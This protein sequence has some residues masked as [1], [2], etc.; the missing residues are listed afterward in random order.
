MKN[1]ANEIQQQLGRQN[2]CAFCWIIG[3]CNLNQVNTHNL[4]AL[5]KALQQLQNFII[6]K[7]AMAGGA[8]S[9]VLCLIITPRPGLNLA[10]FACYV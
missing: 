4:A 7:P 2:L 6:L 9:W 1:K 3:W 8:G 10:S 5:G